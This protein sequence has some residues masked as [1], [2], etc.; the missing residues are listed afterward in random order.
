MSSFFQPSVFSIIQGNFHP[1]GA[2]FLKPLQQFLVLWM[3]KTFHCLAEFFGQL[4]LRR[5]TASLDQI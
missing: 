4:A 1:A 5:M 3:Q 2:S